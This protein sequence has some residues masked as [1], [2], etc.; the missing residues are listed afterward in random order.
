[1][2]AHHFSLA[3]YTRDLHETRS[4]VFG[5]RSFKPRS[6]RYLPTACSGSSFEG[7]GGC[8]GLLLPTFGRISVIGH[9]PTV[10][11]GCHA[12]GNRLWD[13]KDLEPSN[14]STLD[15]TE[16]RTH[17]SGTP[18]AYSTFQQRNNTISKRSA[19][20]SRMTGSRNAQESNCSPV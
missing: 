2:N 8:I 15:T 12:D 17:S 7:S 19:A 11:R 6:F 20:Q 13:A 16:E 4:T 1:M 3:A 18:R 14:P 5:N 10:I 9:L